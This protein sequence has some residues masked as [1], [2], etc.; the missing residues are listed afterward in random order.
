[1]SP[2]VGNLEAKGHVDRQEHPVTL[3]LELLRRKTYS[4][5]MHF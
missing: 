2:S 3:H 5:P 1:M 4:V